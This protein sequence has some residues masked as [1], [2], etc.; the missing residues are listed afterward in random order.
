MCLFPAVLASD[1]ENYGREASIQMT[2][3]SIQMTLAIQMA[4][5]TTFS[6]VGFFLS[7]KL[8]LSCTVST[9]QAG[10]CVCVCE[11]EREKKSIRSYSM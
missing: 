2:L 4:L 5:A 11:S 10:V 3:A 6:V 7:G 1:R 8:L 9:S